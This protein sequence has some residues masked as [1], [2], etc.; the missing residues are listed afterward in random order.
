MCSLKI[1][2][3]KNLCTKIG[4]GAT[5]KGGKESY[6]NHGISLIRSQN[7]LMNEFSLDGLAYI[8]DRQASELRNVIVQ[9]DDVLL[10]ITGD[11][12]ARVCQAPAWILPARVN[13][14][15]AIIRPDPTTLNPT[16]LRYFLASPKMQDFML[17]LASSGATRQALTKAMIE[18]F[19]IPL[20]SMHIQNR[21]ADTLNQLDQKIEVNKKI[22][23][24]LESMVTAIFKEWFI[25]FGPVKAK[26]EGRKPFGMDDETA[27]L[28]PDS[29]E[30]S[31]LGMIP[32][33][34]QVSTYSSI[35]K[36]IKD[37]VNPEN[38]GLS[39]CIHYSLPNFDAGKNAKNEQVADIKSNKFRVHHNSILFSK[40]NPR[41]PRI[42][43]ANH[44]ESKNHKAVGSTEF[45]VI[46]PNLAENRWLAYCLLNESTFLDRMAQTATGTSNSHQRIK[47]ESIFET[48]W[49]A[50]NKE[51]IEHFHKTVKSLFELSLNN[52]K[53]IQYLTQTRDL[54]LPKL[55]SGEISLDGVSGD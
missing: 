50:P 33:G 42:W 55:I 16:Y 34:W 52:L 8:D 25:D 6:K 24:T 46:H 54:L 18:D 20:P 11:S 7:I 51:V 47:P 37:S 36:H 5:P 12:V 21:I 35:M 9:T 32:T 40:L 1:E 41:T 22:N 17:G 45:V 23:E 39:E 49:A 19:E 43:I 53:E 31:E 14:H 4:S 44:N 3:L 27:S 2:K 28:F 48:K 13:Q 38:F 29:F 10:N 26:A 15:V 30:E